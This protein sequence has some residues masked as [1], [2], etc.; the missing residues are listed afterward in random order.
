[1]FWLVRAVRAVLASGSSAGHAERRR[2]RRYDKR[3]RD[4]HVLNSRR[5]AAGPRG[6]GADTDLVVYPPADDLTRQRLP[7]TR[8]LTD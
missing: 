8:A 1:M 6:D 7:L 4:S 3:H 2:Q 5:P